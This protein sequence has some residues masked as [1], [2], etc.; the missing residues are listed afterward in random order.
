[1]VKQT[2]VLHKRLISIGL[3]KHVPVGEW[4]EEVTFSF[5]KLWLKFDPVKAETMEKRGEGLHD[6]KDADR[7]IRQSL[8][9]YNEWRLKSL[10][11][12]IN[13]LIV[14]RSSFL[15]NRLTKNDTR[16]AQKAKMTNIMRQPYLR[17]SKI[18]TASRSYKTFFFANEEF[19]CFLLLS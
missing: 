17:R 16:N 3:L 4:L 13:F 15:K 9:Q 11:V 2:R 14:K 7:L 18:C 1:M 6:A 12:L 19:L 5:I 10:D 8:R